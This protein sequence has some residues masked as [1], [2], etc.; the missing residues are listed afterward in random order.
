VNIFIIQAVRQLPYQD[1]MEAIRGILEFLPDLANR[2]ALSQASVQSDEHITHMVFFHSAGEK[3]D[4][5]LAYRPNIQQFALRVSLKMF[6][7]KF[8]G[9]AGI[10]LIPGTR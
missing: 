9:I 4:V 1:P 3:P 7:E 6:R 10:R 5:L 2:L 8:Q